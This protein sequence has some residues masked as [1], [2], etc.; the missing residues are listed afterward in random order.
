M[1]VAGAVDAAWA[2]E[3]PEPYRF[4]A[5]NP[6]PQDIHVLLVDDERVSRTVVS[7]LLQ[8]CGYRV[9]VAESGEEVLRKIQSGKEQ[10]NLILSDV[11]MPGVNGLD[12]IKAVR[13]DNSL[14]HIPVIMMS[15]QENAGTV[16]EAIR[17]GAEDYLLKP[18]TMKEV[19]HLWQHVWRRRFSWQKVPRMDKQGNE[20]VVE[21]KEGREGPPAAKRAKAGAEDDSEDDEV[22]VY[23]AAEMRTH[24]LRQIARYQ[25]VVE[26]IDTHP[27]VFPGF[28][29]G[30]AAPPPA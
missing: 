16:F 12:I 27:E 22:G 5:R 30:G 17:S 6:Q 13:K 18:V 3:V 29:Q 8:K 24:C 28:Q 4:P 25:R 19:A 23:S 14:V 11:M 2:A 21:E 7:K 26:I 15:S 20:E 10:F 9:T 1:A